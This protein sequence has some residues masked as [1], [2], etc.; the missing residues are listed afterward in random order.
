M[1]VR[2]RGR[3]AVVR[4]STLSWLQVC[5]RNTGENYKACLDEQFIGDLTNVQAFRRRVRLACTDA[6]GSNGRTER[7]IMDSR[8]GWE[9]IHM[10]CR[11]HV[12]AGIHTKVYS[13][14]SVEQGVSGMI[15]VALA[16]AAAGEMS[17][18]RHAVRR[19]LRRKLR[20]VDGLALAA[21]A[22][23]FRAL[24]M[25]TFLGESPQ[26]RSLA[27]VLERCAPGDW[28]D[29]S[30]VYVRVGNESRQDVLRLLFTQFVPALFGSCP[31]SFPRSRWTGAEK[32]FRDIGLP[33]NIH[34]LLADSYMEYMCERH[35]E[36]AGEHGGGAQADDWEG[37]DASQRALP[38]A[39]QEV[40]VY[41]GPP[42]GPH[43]D[44]GQDRPLV[45]RTWAEQNK[46]HRGKAKEWLQSEP[47]TRVLLQAAVHRPLMRLLAQELELSSGLWETKQNAKVVTTPVAPGSTLLEGRSWL[48]LT[49]AQGRLEAQCM[50]GVASLDE[51][52][53]TSSLQ[54][55]SIR[56]DIQTLLCQ[57]IS[58]AGC[59]IHQLLD[60]RRKVFPFRLFLLLEDR[61]LA[62]EILATCS[63]SRDPYSE[64][65]IAYYKDTPGGLT[66][67]IALNE[68]A[69]LVLVARTCTAPLECKNA[70]IRSLV[71]HSSIQTRRPSLDLVSARFLLR[72]LAIRESQLAAPPGKLVPRQPRKPRRKGGGDARRLSSGGAR[73]RKTGGG[74]AWRAF[75]SVRS[76]HIGKA[77]FR[78]LAREYRELTPEAQ[79]E[80]IRHGAVATTLHRNARPSFG[81]VARSLVRRLQDEASRARAEDALRLA[82]QGC[83]GSAL[84]V[85]GLASVDFRGALRQC[86]ADH[87]LLRKFRRKLDDEA[88]DALLAWR[89]TSGVKHRDSFIAAVPFAA[90]L[91]LGLSAGPHFGES[92]VLD[93]ICP[94]GL[95]LPR[96]ASLLLQDGQGHVQQAL[97]ADWSKR[98]REKQHTEQVPLGF[99]PQRQQHAKPSCLDAGLCLCGQR[100]D[101]VHS[102]KCFLD[103]GI[104]KLTK[105]PDMRQK[106]AKSEIVVRCIK[107]T[108][109][110][111]GD[112]AGTQG[113]A[114]A[115]NEA[116]AISVDSFFRGLHVVQ[117]LPGYLSSVLVA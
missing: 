21:D 26:D 29:P 9:H 54:L 38:I 61:A 53:R 82:A 4:G 91:V 73:R 106:L 81:M 85:R 83:G 17:S 10:H 65:F 75:I 23:Q 102:F 8:P 34:N 27:M 77:M 6:A 112:A 76:K 116:G 57:M 41:D 58:R 90:P 110:V 70:Q 71:Q 12:V 96:M 46:Q 69:A 15:S 115:L 50:E 87:Y 16:L 104:K 93:W 100:G 97:L 60:C 47:A 59:C 3:L 68:L 64:S 63:S 94:L 67:E 86:K 20:I 24:V 44:R 5:D 30:F 62:P 42:E 36:E 99:A 89:S 80:F 109:A 95:V 113:R 35:D 43:D 56:L 11:V 51:S 78:E 33:L 105:E 1:L 40:V 7:H 107:Y 31:N 88:A 19:T 48:L 52:L 45:G 18:F 22:V 66:S 55:G 25:R 49:C 117:A 79:Q 111:P 101:L 13:I 39:C 84:A 28:R 108:G 92:F 14:P 74:G 72:R 37:G 103:N 114:E 2:F 32:T 98:H